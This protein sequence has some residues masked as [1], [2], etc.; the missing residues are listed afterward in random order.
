M[1]IAGIKV[2]RRLKSALPPNINSEYKVSA[3]KSEPIQSDKTKIPCL[4]GFLNIIILPNES[5]SNTGPNHRTHP[6]G[7]G[8]PPAFS[9]SNSG[10]NKYMIP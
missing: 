6:S 8:S 2:V 7:I 9:I 1:T 4:A 3:T 5:A 10:K